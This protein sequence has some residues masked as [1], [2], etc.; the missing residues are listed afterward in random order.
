MD[1][2]ELDKTLAVVEGKSSV[3]V[4]FPIP[5]VKPWKQVHRGGHVKLKDDIIIPVLLSIHL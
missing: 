5:A 3:C 4:A 1:E 2:E